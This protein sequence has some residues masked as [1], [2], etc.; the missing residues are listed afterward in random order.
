M[1]MVIPSLSVVVEYKKDNGIKRGVFA[2]VDNTDQTGAES[3]TVSLASVSGF[4]PIGFETSC[5]AVIF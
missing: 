3:V 4:P 1:T 5:T 2:R